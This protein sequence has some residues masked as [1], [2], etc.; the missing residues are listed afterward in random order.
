MHFAGQTNN[1]AQRASRQS[2]SNINTSSRQDYSTLEIG[3][4][5][6]SDPSYSPSSY[7]PTY[8][9]NDSDSYTEEHFDTVRTY[10][11]GQAVLPTTSPGFEKKSSNGTGASFQS[12][13]NLHPSLSANS[14]RERGTADNRRTNGYES[15]AYQS[16][17][18]DYELQQTHHSG[19]MSGE[20]KVAEKARQQSSL[21]K[22]GFYDAS[23]RARTINGAGRGKYA[24][25]IPEQRPPQ[26]PL[27][28]AR[29]FFTNEA[30]IL[31]MYTVLSLITRMWRIG[32]N[33]AVVWDEAHF[34]KFGSHYLKHEFYFDVHPP[35]GK[36]LV[37]LAGLLSGYGGQFEFKSG[38]TYPNDV[39]YVGMRVIMAMFGVAMVPLAWSSS[40]ALGWNW[41]TRHALTI[42]VLFDNAWLVISR[43]I[44]LDSM[45]LCF[46]FMTVHGLLMFHRHRHE[47][48]GEQWWFWLTF[49]GFSIGFVASVKWVGLFATALVGLYT[50]EDLWDK[51][52]DLKMPVR[53][54]T[55]HWCA[56]I[57]CLIVLPMAV[58]MI[59]FKVHF[60]ILS[61][62]GP[63]DA[64]MSS[65]FQAH[66]R[67][68]DFAQAPLEAAYGS[69][70]TFKNMGYGGGLLHSHVQT[71]PVGS[72]QQQ[73][74]CY[75]YRD[76]NNEFIITP[77]W[78]DPPL[79]SVNDTD[80]PPPKML[81]S[82]SVIRLVH[83]QTGRNLH[84]HNFPAPVTKENL[85]VSGYGSAEI[86]DSNDYWVVEVVDDMN[87]GKKGKAGDIV[88]SLTTRMRLK[89][90]NLGCYLRAANAI[91]PQWG[92]K[93]VEVSCDKENNPK[94]EHTY[95]NI[96]THINPRLPMGNA[97]LYR[98]PF[99]RDFVHLNVAMMTSNNA[100]IPD[101]DKEDILASK[102]YDWPW[103][104]NGL[105]MNGWGDTNT[106][107]YLIGNPVIWW[108]SSISLIAYCMTYLW[109]KGRMQ[110]RIVDLSPQDWEQ[111]V[112]AGKVAGLG[113]FLHYL[114]F[115]IMARVC[116]I[117]HYLPTLYFAV[118]MMAHLLD[119]FLWNSSTAR[120]RSKKGARIPLSEEIKN[121]TFV[122]F[123]SLV[124]GVFWWFRETAWGIDGPVWSRWG[125]KWRKS[126]N[127]KD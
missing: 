84:S 53:R 111:F 80:P 116:Y 11:S 14:A 89:H 105:R 55:R 6:P 98:S 110:R 107:Y 108:G 22:P 91:L 122:L 63:G 28:I 123:C 100:L 83:E 90:Q 79:P 41:R 20:D 51:F 42:M 54:Y 106:K 38:E 81:R 39:N 52:G 68:N 113:W 29:R 15:T 44:L 8:D 31:G 21:E 1:L 85:E 62:S 95:W 86:G 119:H 35:L 49:T 10:E 75:H 74:T 2:T 127:I 71:Y 36:M 126:W 124:I 37:G 118:L 66:L 9:R 12:K 93:Q 103:L 96:E 30:C 78:E 26:S 32:K 48:F 4:P 109:Y 33:N 7:N 101:Q 46:T 104:Y 64:Q 77:P 82:G 25:L 18:N 94:D 40:G 60:L 97:K 56:R 47:S 73:V 87:S 13:V 58:Y 59:S 17:N 50:M 67:G 114:P 70:V 112:F 92:W 43:F 115:L 65:L 117:H 69:K 23:N 76:N 27:E 99:L 72:Q 16:A 61:R 24:N 45:L 3:P 34:G 19:S 88:H 102:P 57:L 121:I 125:I 120:Y 5:S